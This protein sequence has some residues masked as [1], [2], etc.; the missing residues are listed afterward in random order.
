MIFNTTRVSNPRSVFL[1]EEIKNLE[2]KII[3]RT[4]KNS[5]EY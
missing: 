2:W 1:N 4:R 3:I 5:C